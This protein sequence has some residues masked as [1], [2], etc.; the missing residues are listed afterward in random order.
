MTRWLGWTAKFVLSKL[1]KAKPPI[2]YLP[3]ELPDFSTAAFWHVAKKSDLLIVLD[4]L[5]RAN[6]SLQLEQL[7]GLASSITENSRAKVLLVFNDAE[8]QGDD[9]KTLARLRE[10]VIDGE[11][12][13]RPRLADLVA[14]HLCEPALQETVMACLNIAGG[15]NI[16]QI[17]RIKHGIRFLRD[18]KTLQTPSGSCASSKCPSIQHR[19]PITEKLVKGDVHQVNMSPSWSLPPKPL[20]SCAKPSA[21]GTPS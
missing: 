18:T 3:V 7:F 10:K 1:S 19:D 16:R 12:T 4:D 17:R 8:L 6:P 13:F 14:E 9:P 20:D 2:P 15:P 21:T 5:E 11:F